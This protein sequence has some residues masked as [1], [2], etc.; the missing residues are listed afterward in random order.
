MTI[1][2]SVAGGSG[3]DGGPEGLGDAVSSL[4]QGAG[5]L[6]GMRDVFTMFKD[7]KAAAY[8]KLPSFGSAGGP[9]DVEACCVSPVRCAS[10]P[11]RFSLMD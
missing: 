5:I 4:Q 2:G 1:I 10:H 8:G 11:C 7:V 6:R 9:L 3:G